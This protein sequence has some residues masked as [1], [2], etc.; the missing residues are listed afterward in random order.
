ME[1]YKDNRFFFLL[2]AFLVFAYAIVALA[3]WLIRRRSS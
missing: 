2:L 3:G 1:F